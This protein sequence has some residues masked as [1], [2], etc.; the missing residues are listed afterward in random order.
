MQPAQ[1]PQVPTLPVARP[2]GGTGSS[3]PWPL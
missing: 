3:G 1:R 2:V